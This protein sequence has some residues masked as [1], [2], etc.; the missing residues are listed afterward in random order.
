MPQDV[1]TGSRRRNCLVALLVGLALVAVAHVLACAADGPR[2]HHGLAAISAPATVVQ[3]TDCPGEGAAHG[4]GPGDDHDCCSPA[5]H[6]CYG[7]LRT[8][9]VS[10]LMLLLGLAAV[11]WAVPYEQRVRLGAGGRRAGAPPPW[12]GLQLLRLVCVSRT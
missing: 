10:L 6:A 11:G 1:E 5:G 4:H 3:G 8:E 7:P 12:P 2:G 9:P